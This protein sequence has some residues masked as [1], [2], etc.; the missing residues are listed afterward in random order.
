MGYY[1]SYGGPALVSSAV[2]LVG[3]CMLFRDRRLHWELLLMEAI[4]VDMLFHGDGEEFNVSPTSH[5][6]G[7]VA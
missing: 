7:Y 3:A 6:P 4:F 1:K 2:L 5:S